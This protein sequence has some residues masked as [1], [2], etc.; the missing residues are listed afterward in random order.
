MQ[1]LSNILPPISQDLL[2]FS[3]N[4]TSLH[5]VFKLSQP[6]QLKTSATYFPMVQKTRD[7][8]FGKDKLAPSESS[9]ESSNFP[10]V[11]LVRGGHLCLPWPFPTA[12]PAAF[13]SILPRETR[14]IIQW[15]GPLP[16]MQLTQIWLPGPHK[17]NFLRQPGGFLNS[18][19]WAPPCDPTFQSKQFNDHFCV[20]H[21]VFSYEDMICAG[22][23]PHTWLEQNIT[24]GFNIT[25]T[26]ADATQ[27]EDSW[28]RVGHV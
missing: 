10:S 2:Q 8:N 25:M 1:Q 13:F 5:T 15:V 17:V 14:G 18:E 28:R 12:V 19:P 3:L 11:P 20:H 23:C 7:L 24:K 6:R 27:E 16:C 4:I 26:P 22:C 21:G 9:I